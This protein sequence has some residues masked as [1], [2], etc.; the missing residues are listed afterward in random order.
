[1][2]DDLW[3]TG[4]S[5]RVTAEAVRRWRPQSLT[6]LVIGTV[7]PAFAARHPQVEAELNH[8]AVDGLP[9]LAA[10]ARVDTLA[11]NQRMCKFVLNHRPDEVREWLD[12][13]PPDLAWRLH[14]A[15]LAEGFGLTPAFRDTVAVLA[16]HVDERRLDERAAEAGWVPVP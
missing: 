15:A 11:V 13:V 6:Y 7:E 2:V 14:S 16:A 8:A 3:V 4:T 12:A 5:A 1:V 9:A 10:L